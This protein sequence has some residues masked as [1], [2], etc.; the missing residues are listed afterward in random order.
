MANTLNINT[1]HYNGTIRSGSLCISLGLTFELDVY[2]STPDPV[3]GNLFSV[4]YRTLYGPALYEHLDVNPSYITYYKENNKIKGELQLNDIPIISA[5]DFQLGIYVEGTAIWEGVAT[6]TVTS[7]EIYVMNDCSEATLENQY[8]SRTPTNLIFGGTFT[9]DETVVTDWKITHLHIYYRL[10]DSSEMYNLV[11]PDHHFISANVFQTSSEINNI[12]SLRE[13]GIEAYAEFTIEYEILGS[14]SKNYTILT[15]DPIVIPWSQSYANKCA[16]I[17]ITDAVLKTDP[18]TGDKYTALYIKT[19]NYYADAELTSTGKSYALTD[20]VVKYSS[21][22]TTTLDREKSLGSAGGIK[23]SFGTRIKIGRLSYFQVQATLISTRISSSLV[24]S[25]PEDEETAS[26]LL[27]LNISSISYTDGKI[28]LKCLV[29]NYSSNDWNYLKVVSRY[30]E[31]PE[32]PDWNK[33]ALT[34]DLD[35]GKRKITYYIEGAGR[36]QEWEIY[37]VG[38]AEIG[39]KTYKAKSTVVSFTT[40]IKDHPEQ[41][42]LKIYNTSL[43]SNGKYE[44]FTEF[45]KVPTYNVQRTIVEET[46]EDANYVTHS[47]TARY[48]IKGSFELYFDTREKYYHFIDL[49]RLEKALIISGNNRKS[50]RNNTVRMSVQLNDVIDPESITDHEIV[51][52]E[53]VEDRD[54]PYVRCKME[55][56]AFFV[57]IDDLPWQVPYYQKPGKEVDTIKVEIEEE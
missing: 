17:K 38:T 1:T 54:L 37:L 11:E 49:L 16:Y 20:I 53:A 23:N 46:W 48:K 15:S 21:Q 13:L 3:F 4:Y 9:I 30:D 52:S 47:I 14:T 26:S 32:Y 56:S 36:R 18:E 41:S 2:S 34:E 33:A 39:D 6:D 35:N 27:S 5:S 12:L 19:V 28:K 29:E 50:K 43:G 10:N 55:Q 7:N 22:G 45:I 57:K 8:S 40:L 24:Q 31:D 51:D 42:L 44:D 25:E